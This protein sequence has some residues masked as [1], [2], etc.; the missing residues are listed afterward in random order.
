MLKNECSVNNGDCLVNVDYLADECNGMNSCSIQL[1]SQY[2]HSCKNYSNYITIAYKCLTKH[3]RIDVCSNEEYYVNDNEFY[4]K[5][6]NY[7]YEYDNNLS[8]CTC[9]IENLNEERFDLKFEV[10]F[11]VFKS[12]FFILLKKINFFLFFFEASCI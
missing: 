12:L 6:P 5:T 7:P 4:I 1:D 2:L 3:N 8:N 10:S 11:L 9:K